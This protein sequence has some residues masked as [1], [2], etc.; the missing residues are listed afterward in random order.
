ML[1]YKQ[2]KHKPVLD[3]GRGIR[4]SVEIRTTKLYNST[5]KVVSKTRKQTKIT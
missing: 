4:T 3:Y 1:R 2:S 5:I